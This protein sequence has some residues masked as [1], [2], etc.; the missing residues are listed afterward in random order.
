MPTPSEKLR[1]YLK[2]NRAI[3]SGRVI[4]KEDYGYF[5]DFVMSS[6]ELMDGFRDS[7]EY[8][9]L[10]PEERQ[11]QESS[12]QLFQN[13]EYRQ[14][15]VDVLENSAKSQ[16]TE[17]TTG[18]INA[19]LSGLDVATS[20]AQI[21]LGK[22]ASDKLQRPSRPAPLTA[23]PRL[24]QELSEASRGRFDS[25][26][27]LAPA[28]L[29][30]LD[31]YLSDLNT[32]KTVS[33]GQASTYGALGQVASTRRA[34]GAQGLVPIADEI[35]RSQDARYDSLLGLKLQENQAINQSQGQYYPTDLYQYGREAQAAASLGA[36][37][38]SNLR[39]SLGA[40]GQFLPQ[41]LAGEKKRYGDI[42]NSMES[43]YPGQGALAAAADI[44]V[45]TPS[46][47]Y[48]QNYLQDRFPDL[49]RSRSLP[50]YYDPYKINQ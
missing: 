21:N 39:E 26:R 8:A 46:T 4:S 24:K 50:S 10:S 44:N 6:E 25:V 32:A 28:Q 37:G 23:E 20:I 30:L 12:L 18:F 34:K 19:A 13:P 40:V 16:R 3:A 2:I 15:L 36:T 49:Y 9:N 38:R 14:G 42:Y 41:A 33:G 11:L 35:R 22:Q 7:P 29:A 27:A 31:N 5:R 1:R 43:A 47:P 48:A 45:R 17:K